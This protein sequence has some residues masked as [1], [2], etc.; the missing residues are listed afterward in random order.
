MTE[1][2]LIKISHHGGR[3][4]NDCILNSMLV[5]LVVEDFFFYCSY[6]LLTSPCENEDLYPFAHFLSLSLPTLTATMHN[7]NTIEN[8]SHCYV[9]T[10]FQFCVMERVLEMDGDDY[11]TACVQLVPLNGT[12]KLG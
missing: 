6:S 5:L 2:G 8:G 11:P 9:G 1:L 12:L 3:F 4:I 10:K 7:S